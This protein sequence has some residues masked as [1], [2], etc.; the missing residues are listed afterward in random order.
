MRRLYC[1]VMYLLFFLIAK[2]C[3]F[4]QLEPKLGIPIG[5]TSSISSVRLSHN[6]KVLLSGSTDNVVSAW[7]AKSGKILFS[8]LDHSQDISSISISNDDSLMLSASAKDSVVYV[9]NLS[10]G[11]KTRTIM[12]HLKKPLNTV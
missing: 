7:D 6:Q 8:I 12:F 5:H 9:W 10:T 4:G 1:A 2:T 3:L 11:K